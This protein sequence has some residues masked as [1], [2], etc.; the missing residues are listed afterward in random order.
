M[1]AA[2]AADDRATSWVG[3]RAHVVHVPPARDFEETTASRKMS[4][5]SRFSRLTTAS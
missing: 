1:T 4:A 3:V 2:R 5:Y